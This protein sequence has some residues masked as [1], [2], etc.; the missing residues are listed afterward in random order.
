[1]DKNDKVILYWSS[2]KSQETKPLHEKAREVE[3]NLKQQDGSWQIIYCGE[4][5][6]YMAGICSDYGNP[7][8]FAETMSL[9]ERILE[10]F[11]KIQ[12]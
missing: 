5:D 11:G 1:M 10:P 2:G 9:F 3:K 4:S 12:C 8:G 7:N 6:L